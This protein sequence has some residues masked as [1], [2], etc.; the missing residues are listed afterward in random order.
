MTM[1]KQ[2]LKTTTFLVLVIFTSCSQAPEKAQ[3]R[4]ENRD[5]IFNETGLLASWPD[6]GPALLWENEDIGDGYG[7]PAVTSD[8]LYVNG[9]IDS[10]SHLFAYNLDG[11]LAWKS[12][13]GKSFTGDGFS[14]SF[15]GS[16]SAPTVIGDLVYAISGLGRVA[17]FETITGTEKWST[18]LV[19]DYNGKPNY[20]GYA[21][22]P[23]ID[24]NKLFC[25]PG[26]KDTNIIALDRYTGKPLWISK[27]LSDTVS[28]C[29]PMLISLPNRKILV[30]FSIHNLLGLDAETGELLWSHNQ[31][32]T[33]FNQ[34]SNTPVYKDGFIYYAQRDGNG[35]VKLEL[36][37]DG[38]SIKEVWRKDNEGNTFTSFVIHKDK[39]YTSSH[40]PKLKAFDINSGELSDTLKMKCGTLI[41]DTDKLY[42]YAD[43]GSVSMINTTDS[44]NIISKF[45]IKKGTKEHF[46]SPVIKNGVLYIRHGNALMAYD[47]KEN[48]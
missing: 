10:T 40:Q 46:A 13:N 7:S 41:S 15:P 30:T 45:K 33:R 26:N 11:T 12:P 19:D 4:G 6:K 17:C 3:W 16:R 32:V 37:Q 5:G 44:L 42:C 20:F 2:A 38:S 43:N 34:P 35:I 1:I 9:E 18:H 29:S 47:I 22:S 28:Y 8:K 25:F 48:S 31:K 39:L 27:A 14:S 21:E 24:E 23:L 36:S